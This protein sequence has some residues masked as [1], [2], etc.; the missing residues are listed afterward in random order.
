M[1]SPLKCLGLLPKTEVAL[2]LERM[3]SATVHES[4]KEHPRILFILEI[5]PVFE[6]KSGSESQKARR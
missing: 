2:Q 1:C 6:K 4:I 5:G 3:R